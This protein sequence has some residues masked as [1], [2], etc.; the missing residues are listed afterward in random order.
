[1]LGYVSALALEPPQPLLEVSSRQ[2]ANG[3]FEWVGLASLGGQ[4]GT[5]LHACVPLL[6]TALRIRP[7]KRVRQA[8]LL[9]ADVEISFAEDAGGWLRL[10]I[11][12]VD[13]YEVLLLEYV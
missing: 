8:R 6:G 7:Q 12:R 1:L 11:P 13:R 9:R 2:D 3:A 5:A 10:T 4:N